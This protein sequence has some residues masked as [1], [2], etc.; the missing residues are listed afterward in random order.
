MKKF[1]SLLLSVVMLSLCSSLI[2]PIA[3]GGQ[4][5]SAATAQEIALSANEARFL[6]MLNHNFVYNSD[7]D[8]IDT[9]VNN[10]ALALL[11]LRDSENEDYVAESFVKGFVSDMY[12]I[13]IAD[14]SALNAEFPQ[15]DGYLY[16]I[17]RG[18]DA[19]THTIVSVEENE[20]GS[21]TVISDVAISRH[22]ADTQTQKAVSLFVENENSAFGYNMIFC[23]IIFD[24][25]DI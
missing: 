15:L 17:P 21:Y 24:S 25:T 12:G 7:F 13:E 5:V 20:D 23:N 4:E 18:Y 6:N 10:A 8:D 1:L 11:D 14:M 2:T 19:Y 16:I 9:V 3:T 22:D